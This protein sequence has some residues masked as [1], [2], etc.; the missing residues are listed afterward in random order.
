MSF[1]ARFT[2]SGSA[3][4][5]RRKWR[6]IIVCAATLWRAHFWRL[7]E[8]AAQ[9]RPIHLERGRSGKFIDKTPPDRN[10]R[11]RN[12]LPQM[13]FEVGFAGRC[14]PG[15]ELDGGGRH[16]SQPPVGNANDCGRRDGRMQQQGPFDRLGQQL[17]AAAHDGAVGAATMKGKANASHLS[18][19]GGA[20]R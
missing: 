16:V 15:L 19:R 17:E 14:A 5:V 2:V 3:A 12:V 13:S 20:D 18:Y 6:S 11:C 8:K 4:I 9:S 7:A 1:P 10:V